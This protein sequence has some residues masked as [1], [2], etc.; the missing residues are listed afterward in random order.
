MRIPE[1]RFAVASCQNV[2][3]MPTEKL[4]REIADL[5]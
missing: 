2:G 3:N 1:K 4:A 5:Y